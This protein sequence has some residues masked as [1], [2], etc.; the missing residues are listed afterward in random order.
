LFE[1]LREGP[2]SVSELAAT[3]PVSQPA[4]SQHLRV[5]KE[6]HLVKVEKQGQQRIYSLNPTGLAEL[7][8]YVEAFWE[9]ALRAFEVEAAWVA[10]GAANAQAE[11]ASRKGPRTEETKSSL[12]KRLSEDQAKQEDHDE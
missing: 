7:R 3:V 1:R 9:D 10:Q 2:C 5:L 6:A 11:A 8:H 4:V 12:V